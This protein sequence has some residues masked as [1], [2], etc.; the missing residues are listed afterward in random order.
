MAKLKQGDARMKVNDCL[1]DGEVADGYRLTCQSIP[2][3]SSLRIQY[4]D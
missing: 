1:D 3:T 4:P 2:T